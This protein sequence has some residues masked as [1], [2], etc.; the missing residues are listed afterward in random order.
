MGFFRIFLTQSYHQ[1]RVWN[2]EFSDFRVSLSLKASSHFLNLAQILT[3]LLQGKTHDR[4][5][6]IVF[7][8]ADV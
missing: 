8:I 1:C 2:L 4:S 6:D 7:L 3:L 5:L